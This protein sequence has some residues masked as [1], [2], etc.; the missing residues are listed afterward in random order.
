MLRIEHLKEG[1]IAKVVEIERLCFSAPKSEAIFRSDQ[2]KYLVAKEGNGI[3]GYIG[4]ERIAG[5]THI[6]NM[7]VHPDSQGKGIGKELLKA[8]LNDPDVVFLEVRASNVP[9]QKV[10]QHFGFKNVGL[11]ENYYSDNNEDAYILR[12]EP[13]EQ[14]S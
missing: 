4:T 14:I 7:A 8:V 6:I 5:E 9:A 11:R 10:Y 2:S 1:D 13:G 12:R 3:V